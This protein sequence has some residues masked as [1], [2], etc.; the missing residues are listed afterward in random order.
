MTLRI[1]VLGINYAP[2]LTGIGR[3]TG[4]MASWLAARGHDV[5]VVT[6][7][8][9]Y[10]QWKVANGYSTLRYCQERKVNIRVWRCPLY[11][12]SS[13]SGPKRL[14]HLVSFAASSF[15]VM[16]RQLFWKPDVVMG[17]EPPLFCAPTTWLI[18]KL[19]G[20]RSWL[21]VQDFEV[22]A[23]FDVGV[24]SSSWMRSAVVAVESWLMRR[25][26]CVSTISPSMF[27]RLSVKG[28]DE[29]RAT[30][31][32][33][34]ADLDGVRHDEAAAAEF[35]S[36]H[37][38]PATAFLAL[39]S[40]NMGEKQGLEIVLDAAH[41]LSGERDVR[42]VLCGDGAARTRLEQQARIRGLDNVRFLPLQSAED[43]AGMLS[44]ADVHLVIQKPG[45]ADLVMPSKL[46]NIMAVGG[47]ALITA[48][49]ET[50]LGRLVT[51]HPFVG[52]LCPPQ[53][54]EGLM[55]AILS[56]KA[57]GGSRYTPRVR[58]YA[59]QA[60]APGQVLGEFESRLKQ[61]AGVG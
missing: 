22:D 8:P 58:R 52:I 61:I 2:E 31:F 7:P 57:L 53:D 50:E 16:L 6:A 42:F 41:R 9:Y 1:L 36:K 17:I 48:A 3:Y 23:A 20:A 59:E 28:V 27:E 13:L 40:G 30:L 56:R 32:P 18:A 55:A 29:E 5:R 33:N 37:G 54:V 4:E 51:E 49:A 34:W 25:F 19:S 21:H 60:I 43:V 12:P 39:Y 46:T 26:D 47:F 14:L 24:L 45:A 11:V 15:P 44:A 10:P 38:V 35:R